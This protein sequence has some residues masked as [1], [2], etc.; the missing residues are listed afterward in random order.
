V[1]DVL[2]EAAALS[3]KDA[4]LLSRSSWLGNDTWIGHN[5][6]EVVV[7]TPVTSMKLLNSEPSYS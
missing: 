5:S 4:P 3:A 7:S 6:V 1:D 2:A